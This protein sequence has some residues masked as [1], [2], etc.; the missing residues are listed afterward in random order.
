VET[1]AQLHM[2][3]AMQCDQIQGYLLGKPVPQIEFAAMM[4]RHI[5]QPA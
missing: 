3:Q 4:Q 5:P 2:L 1:D